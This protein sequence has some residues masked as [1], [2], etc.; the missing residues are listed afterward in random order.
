MVLLSAGTVPWQ[1]AAVIS[2][3]LCSCASK[4]RLR[5][6]LQIVL[7]SQSKTYSLVELDM[8]D[9]QPISA[10]ILFANSPPESSAE[11]NGGRMNI[12][13]RLRERSHGL[14]VPR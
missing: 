6:I 9:A 10:S 7:Q 14:P 2:A 11:L 3:P 1:Y 12:P 4:S 5:S 8:N 13:S